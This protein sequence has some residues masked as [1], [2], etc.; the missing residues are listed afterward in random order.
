MDASDC[1]NNGECVDLMGI[2][3]PRKQCFCDAG[4][5]GEN[6]EKGGNKTL[7][8]VHACIYM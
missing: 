4:Y 6:C 3:I 7:I 1:S 2:S 8:Y 5:F